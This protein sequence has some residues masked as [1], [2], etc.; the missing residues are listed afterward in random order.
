MNPTHLSLGPRYP[1]PVAPEPVASHHD[2]DIYAAI[3]AIE[4]EVIADY[5]NQEQERIEFIID[6]LYSRGLI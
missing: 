6:H 4:N 2:G 1:E 3:T 5:R